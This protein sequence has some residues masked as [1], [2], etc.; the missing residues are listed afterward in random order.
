MGIKQGWSWENKLFS[1]F[2]RQYLEN[3]T[4]KV[5]TNG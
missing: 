4:T 5:T 1:N 2:M 3:G